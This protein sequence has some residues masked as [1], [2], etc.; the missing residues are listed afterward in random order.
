MDYKIVL[1]QG[2]VKILDKTSTRTVCES[3]ESLVN[4][5][6]QNGW[7]PQGGVSF[8]ITAHSEIFGFQA[9]VKD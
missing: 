3:M 8:V 2:M 7:K 4:A 6:I 1:T 9:I 5:E